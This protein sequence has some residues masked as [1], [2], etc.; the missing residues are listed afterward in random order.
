MNEY[1]DSHRLTSAEILSADGPLARRLPGFVAR[2]GQQEMALRIEAV[3]ADKGFFIAESGT[4][5][6]KTFAYLV[7]ALRSGIKVLISSGTKT[8]QDQIYRRDLPLIRDALAIPLTAALLKGRANYLC[9]HRLERAVSMP[10]LSHTSETAYL[11]AIQQWARRTRKGDIGEITDVSESA[12][13]WPSVTST[14]DN[15]LGTACR[16]YDE[17]YVNRARR[18]ALDADLVI[19][20]HHLFFADLV[21]REEGFGQLLPGVEA[22]IFDEAHQLP[23][24]ATAFFGVSLSGYQLTGLC[25]DVVAEDAREKSGLPQLQERVRAVEKSTADFRLGLGTEP[26]RDV[27]STMEGQ[28]AVLTDLNH[29]RESLAALDE[30]LAAVSGRGEGLASCARRASDLLDRLLTIS[31]ASAPEYVR[32]FETTTRGFSLYMTALDVAAPLRQRLEEG[33]RTWIFTSATLTIDQ[34]FEHYKSQLGLELA[35]TGRWESPFDYK[36][37]A[38]LYVPEGLPDPNHPTYTS[39]VMQ[40]VTPVIEASGGRCFLLF[41]SHRALKLAAEQLRAKISYPLLV[42]GDAPRTEMLERFRHAGDAVLLGTSS[43]WEGVDVRGEALSCVIIDKLPFAS[44]EDPILRARAEAMARAGR[45]PFIEYQ[46]PNAVIALR[47]GTGRL[48]RDENDRGLLVICDPRLLTKGYGRV[49][50]SSLPPVPL[51]RGLDD[52]RQF[53]AAAES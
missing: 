26:K 53:F 12:D 50:L 13:I 38:L 24:I 30:A 16:Y 37:Q 7:P 47:Q 22:V 23:E 52:V 27:W 31:E 48:I 21:L 17:C 20:N 18:E 51:T 39:R 33:D 45:N 19:I 34:S 8:L 10:S 41:T 46:L 11:Q 25:R 5:T 9:L 42:Q 44:P 15:C 28:C 3:L 35:D 6:G 29:L 32:W 2:S 36:N 49:F 40:V 43:F 1:A 14:A 4:G